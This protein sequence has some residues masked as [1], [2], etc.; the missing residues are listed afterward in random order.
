MPERKAILLVAESI[1]GAH[2]IRSVLDGEL[3][4]VEWC[5]LAEAFSQRF[6]ASWPDLVIFDAMLLDDEA[7]EVF[8]HLRQQADLYGVPILV[9]ATILDY[10]SRKKVRRLE[11]DEFIS[12]P[13]EPASLLMRV[14][15]AL[16]LKVCEARS[17]KTRDLEFDLGSFAEKNLA[18]ITR[19]ATSYASNENL[20]TILV[21]LLR[22]TRKLIDFDEGMICVETEPGRYTVLAHV[23][24]DKC[25][26]YPFYEIGES[27]T[28]WL[29]QH[30]L[31]LLV[32]DVDAEMRV[33]MKG[34]EQGLNRA[35]N[36]FVGYPLVQ[37]DYVIG[38]LELAS[39]ERCGFNQQSS[40]LLKPIAQVA[41]IA[42]QN[43]RLP[44][45]LVEQIDH[46]SQDMLSLLEAEPVFQSRVMA[47]IM[48]IAAMIKDSNSSVLITGET[49][50]GKEM[51]ARFIHYKGKRHCYPFFGIN[52]SA[53]PEALQES[54]LFGIEKGT[55][56]G[57][58]K[59]IGKLELVGAGTILLD[60]IVDMPISMQSK[61]L[62]VL[63]ERTFERLGGRD[64]LQLRARIIAA[65]NRD[66][67]EALRTKVLRDDLYYRIAVVHL[68]IP[69]LRERK[70]DIPP[71][72]RYFL[73]QFCME[74]NRPILKISPA[75]MDSFVEKQ[76]PGNVRELRNAVE[77]AVL[78]SPGS[79][80]KPYDESIMPV[81]ASTNSIPHA[82]LLNL[83]FEHGVSIPQFTETYS[84][85]V[86]EK[87][88]Q[89]KS[90]ACQFLKINHRTLS[91]KIE[92]IR[93]NELGQTKEMQSSRT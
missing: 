3:Y 30:K 70:E 15:S 73:R 80:L 1:Q 51:L 16:R 83:A 52:C 10:E 29:A 86:Y 4:H 40:E 71:L 49:G 48:R 22:Q 61:L 8:Q 89:N 41:L 23:G 43:A 50:T 66:I 81:R 74:S 21:E 46:W 76:W 45:G 90:R 56:T 17:L 11:A 75:V 38:T 88:A 91:K 82:S 13:I 44:E 34:R 42:I 54:E 36:S 35:L 28:G 2:C 6:A 19:F 57:V 31:P 67:A 39:Y 5:R 12:K 27:Y 7:L 63:Q 62:R 58:D 87:L 24:G 65:T 20:E 25:T 79:E 77:R 18:K 32:G 68:H 14:E 93:T 64:K 72:V 92:A 78:F 9:I 26:F 37:S 60:E 69:P 33:R 59:K 55:A 53:I 84:R 85:F 47:R